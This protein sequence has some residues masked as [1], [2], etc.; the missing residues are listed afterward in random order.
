MGRDPVHRSG[1]HSGF[2]CM[3]SLLT[4]GIKAI[5]AVA[6]L[7][8]GIHW[9]LRLQRDSDGLT[10]PAIAS[11]AD[12]EMTGSISP[13]ASAPPPPAAETRQAVA[14]APEAPA[15]LASRPAQARAPQPSELDQSHLAALM[16]NASAPAP[17]KAAKR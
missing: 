17:K 12:P 7:S 4:S 13:R 14:P 8:T 1:V 5:L 3:R 16:A 6:A 10:T 9:A 2:D 15:P 11:I